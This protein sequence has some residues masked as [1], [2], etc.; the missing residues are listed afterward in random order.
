[1]P[2]VHPSVQSL[3]ITPICPRSLSFRP[4]LIPPTAKVKLEICGESRLTEVTI[5]GKKICMLSQ[6]DFLEVKMSSY[7]IP[8]VNRIDKGIAWVKDINNLLKWNQSFVNKKHLIHELF[9]T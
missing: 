8:C 7:P 2:I 3:L 4:A 5:D 1:G 6:G 9:E